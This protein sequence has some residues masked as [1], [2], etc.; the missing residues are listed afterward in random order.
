MAEL[1]SIL[2][3]VCDTLESKKISA[4]ISRYPYGGKKQHEAPVVTVGLKSGSTAPSGFAE[5]MGQRYDRVT[6]TY[7]EIYG[8]RLD[9]SFAI[10]IY[11]PKSQAYGAGRCLEIFGEIAEA[12]SSLPSG[13]RVKEILCGETKYDTAVNMFCC[14]AELKFT[15]FLYAEQT[16]DAEFLDFVLKGVLN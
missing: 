15:A 9:M 8:K 4:A 1:D 6:D 2:S 7:N 3:A 10:D 12:C 11:S 14:Q 13:I 5:Y 16:G